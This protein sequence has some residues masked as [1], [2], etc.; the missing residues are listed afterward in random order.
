MGR[1]EGEPWEAESPDDMGGGSPLQDMGGGSP[2]GNWGLLEQCSFVRDHPPPY[3][4]SNDPSV[5]SDIG[6]CIIY[7]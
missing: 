1:S 2:F 7:R 3:Y 5:R 4:T 6:K